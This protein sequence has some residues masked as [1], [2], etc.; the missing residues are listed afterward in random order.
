MAALKNYYLKNNFT[1]LASPL[2]PTL[3]AFHNFTIGTYTTVISV[4]FLKASTAVKDIVCTSQ[5]YFSARH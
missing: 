4:C 1:T 3:T 2:T 5:Y